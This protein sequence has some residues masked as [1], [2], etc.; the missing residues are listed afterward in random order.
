MSPFA[1]FEL[2]RATG[3]FDDTVIEGESRLGGWG[4]VLQATGWNLRAEPNSFYRNRIAQ[5][6]YGLPSYDDAE[7]WQKRLILNDPVARRD[8]ERDAE[9]GARRSQQ[10]AQ[11]A[12]QRYHVEDQRDRLLA[13]LAERFRNGNYTD[14]RDLINT[15]Y[16]AKNDARVRG[17]HGRYVLGIDFD[18]NP[19]EDNTPEQ[20]LQIYHTIAEH[21]TEPNTGYFDVEGYSQA[22]EN[23]M[24][25]LRARYPAFYAFVMRNTNFHLDGLTQQD[26]LSV[27][28]MLG[29]SGG[30]LNEYNRIRESLAARQQAWRAGQQAA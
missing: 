26:R 17:E 9:V 22:R 2:L 18:Q 5:E 11:Y 28:Q 8:F 3:W 21:F 23:Y 1:P 12:D 19:P 4:Q 16:D 15:Y 14:I 25:L 30:S 7:P 10:W 27:M 6:R 20:A 29:G 24:A 13:D